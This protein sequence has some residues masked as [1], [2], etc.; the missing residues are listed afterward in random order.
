MVG[1]DEVPLEHVPREPE[2]L[3]L[4]PRGSNGDYTGCGA[5]RVFLS[6]LECLQKESDKLRSV[7]SHLESRSENQTA[8]MTALNESLISCSHRTDIAENQAQ[9]VTV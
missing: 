6:A 7:N 5:G 4:L 9:N 1:C 8:S 2:L 3:P